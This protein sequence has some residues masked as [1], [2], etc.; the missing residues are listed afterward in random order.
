MTISQIKT[1]TC[2]AILVLAFVVAGFGTASS[3]PAQERE[4]GTGKYTDNER[5]VDIIRPM[6]RD[7]IKQLSIGVNTAVDLS[8]WI[9]L[10]A[11]AA[12]GTAG[13]AAVV[14]GRKTIREEVDSAI[15][16][17][18]DNIDRKITGVEEKIKK[19]EEVVINDLTNKAGERFKRF[20]K[21]QQLQYR[22]ASEVV[23]NAPSKR[24]KPSEI[25]QD[26]IKEYI[27][28][29]DA[30]EQELRELGVGREEIKAYVDFEK[31]GD[32]YHYIRDNNA[33][34]CYHDALRA[35]LTRAGIKVG[36]NVEAEAVIKQT[37][38][39]KRKLG[40]AYASM[41]RNDQAIRQYQ[42]VIVF[43]KD[44]ALAL[45]SL[46]DAYQNKFEY[47]L[48]ADAY[49]AAAGSLVR[50]FRPESSYLEAIYQLANSLAS[51]GKYAEA[52]SHYEEITRR[53][54]V[55]RKFE[56][57]LLSQGEA[58]RKAGQWEKAIA[59]YDR[60]HT[61][62]PG[63]FEAE[64]RKGQAYAGSGNFQ[65]AISAYK[66]VRKIY[67]TKD[68][69]GKYSDLSARFFAYFGD[70][71]R[72]ERMESD[73]LVRALDLAK[74]QYDAHQGCHEIYVLAVCYAMNGECEPAV[75]Y[76]RAAYGENRYVLKWI[77]AA[78]FS[79]FRRIVGNPGFDSLLA[80]LGGR[81]G[82]V[83]TG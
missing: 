2:R 79:D 63:N 60:E 66:N 15:S 56:W 76:L 36:D 40:N 67:G 41:G 45:L 1:A 5:L 49:A 62:H 65:L 13:G 18:I 10:F 29:M 30:L 34:G 73:Y 17:A 55:V 51:Q 16:R 35:V 24:R 11:I 6:V 31:K 52:I 28:Q 53:S 48:A 33:V 78:N 80:E 14:V 64:F 69:K 3:Q 83:A 25:M 38:D 39:I 37:A 47:G 74:E 54:E 61:L 27:E 43:K 42:D 58:H 81:A 70:A 7:D 71:M 26:E 68:D 46:G 22:I 44:D 9:A 8:K 19:R 75:D 77:E 57:V 23:L 82:V 12:I 50:D 72:A 59:C 32:A 21:L 20:V 4:G